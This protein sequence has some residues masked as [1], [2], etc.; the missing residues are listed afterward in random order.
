MDR[1]D[2]DHGLNPAG[3]MHRGCE[4]DGPRKRI[5][6]LHEREKRLTE[7]MDNDL[8]EKAELTND[9]PRDQMDWL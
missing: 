5:M 1:H 8:E 7:A 3:M 2:G 6:K 9:T 4:R